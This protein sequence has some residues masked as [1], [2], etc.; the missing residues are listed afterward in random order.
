MG[1][2]SAESFQY[3]TTLRGILTIRVVGAKSWPEE[4]NLETARELNR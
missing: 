4:L 3:L 2:E 1:R